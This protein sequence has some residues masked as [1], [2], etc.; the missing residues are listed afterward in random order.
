MKDR[1][2]TIIN[3][4]V[5]LIVIGLVLATAATSLAL[6]SNRGPS[7]VSTTLNSATPTPSTV[8]IETVAVSNS[9]TPYATLPPVAPVTASTNGYTITI[10]P[11]SADPSRVLI[12]YTL[13]TPPGHNAA[14]IYFA[15]NIT[16]DWD[17]EGPMLTMRD[18]TQLL[19][20]NIR[21][22]S[23]EVEDFPDLSTPA[24][25]TSATKAIVFDRTRHA[26]TSSVLSLHLIGDLIA[27]KSITY[28][29]V[30]MY[31][32][33]E[34]IARNLS[35]DFTI[36]VDGFRRTADVNQTVRVGDI[37]LTLD[38]VSVTS[39]E[40][41]FFMHGSR[42]PGSNTDGFQGAS[43]WPSNL[44]VRT[45]TNKVKTQTGDYPLGNFNL[46]DTGTRRWVIFY[47]GNLLQSDDQLTMSIEEI[48]VGYAHTDT[49]ILYEGPWAF[50]FTLPQA[51]I[52]AGPLASP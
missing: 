25:A 46:Q 26:N 7:Q 30:F 44:E 43:L 28:T 37:T 5:W 21:A 50:R 51:T 13:T 16:A 10:Y 31:P 34:T 11:V 29:S 1:P 41:V 2:G 52:E 32:I 36:P 24:P 17:L 35:F 4:R 19:A 39:S 33:T 14:A 18:S 27:V 48:V 20:R 8:H 22:S 15:N 49:V 42:E 12:T 6:T 38:R 45:G 3:R 40:A 9:A 23:Q 47:P